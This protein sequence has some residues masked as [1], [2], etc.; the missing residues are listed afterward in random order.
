MSSSVAF[1]DMSEPWKHT[2]TDKEKLE[3]WDDLLKRSEK[4][5]GTIHVDI[6]ELSLD[7]VRDSMVTESIRDSVVSDV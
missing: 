7:N 1:R 4:A 2:W 5:G 6:G 3:K